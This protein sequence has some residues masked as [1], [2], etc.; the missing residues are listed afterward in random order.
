MIF[1]QTNLYSF[2]HLI[3]A[4]LPLHSIDDNLSLS[5][6]KD[7]KIF[8]IIEMLGRS[9]NQLFETDQRNIFYWY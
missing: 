1:S 6:C 3:D 7:H 4:G 8:L 5:L 9:K 2:E